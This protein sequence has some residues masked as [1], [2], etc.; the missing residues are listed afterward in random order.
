MD[1]N[2]ELKTCSNT[3]RYS[4]TQQRSY[5]WGR[6]GWSPPI[7]GGTM[8]PHRSPLAWRR[9]GEGGSEEDEG[10]SIPLSAP[11]SFATAPTQLP[12]PLDTDPFTSVSRGIPF[13]VKKCLHVTTPPPPRAPPWSSFSQSTPLLP[14]RWCPHLHRHRRPCLP[15][16]RRPAPLPVLPFPPPRWGVMLLRQLATPGPLLLEWWPVSPLHRPTT[17]LLPCLTPLTSDVVTPPSSVA[18][19]TFLPHSP[20]GAASTLHGWWIWA[21]MVHG[22]GAGGWLWLLAAMGGAARR[23]RWVNAKSYWMHIQTQICIGTLGIVTHF[24]NYSDLVLGSI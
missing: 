4:P 22:G 11:A 12:L 5:R 23:E 1:W 13:L 2:S 18:L 20:N 6:W 24:Q 15:P 16:D 8:K 10:A 14:H 21:S 17:P 3:N 19:L 7:A 9:R